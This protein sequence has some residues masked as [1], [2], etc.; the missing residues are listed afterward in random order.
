MILNEGIC[1]VIMEISTYVKDTRVHDVFISSLL[2]FL[3]YLKVL[4]VNKVSMAKSGGH[5]V[6]LT[7][8]IYIYIYILLHTKLILQDTK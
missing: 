5:D 7:N 2:I 3:R 4:I 6:I 1:T 8:Y